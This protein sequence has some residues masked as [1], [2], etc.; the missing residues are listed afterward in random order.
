MNI[1]ALSVLVIDD[2]PGVAKSVDMLLRR[3][4]CTVTATLDSKHGVPFAQSLQPDVIL[5]D[6]D[7]PGLSGAQLIKLLKSDPMTM[8]IPVVLMTGVA[9][10]H[11]FTHIPWDAFIQK[12]FGA[13]ELFELLQRTAEKHSAGH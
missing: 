11:M 13:R 10:A 4:G 7:M 12:P 2:D 6:A 8:Q 5:S 1:R 9:E 3:F